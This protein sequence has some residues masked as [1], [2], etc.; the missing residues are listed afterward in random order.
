ML[1]HTGLQVVGVR[2]KQTA[3][4]EDLSDKLINIGSV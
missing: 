4:S 1:A 3:D 2:N